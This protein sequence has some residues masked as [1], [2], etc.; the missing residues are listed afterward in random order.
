MRLVL[1]EVVDQLGG[2]RDSLLYASVFFKL[3]VMYDRNAHSQSF[4]PLL[5]RQQLKTV[6][7]GVGKIDA[8]GIASAAADFTTGLFQYGLDL[9]ILARL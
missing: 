8:V 7:V 1:L 9:F 6:A 4:L 3:P 5:R 2:G